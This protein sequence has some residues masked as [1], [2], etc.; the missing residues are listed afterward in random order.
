LIKASAL[1]DWCK[2]QIGCGYVYG[3]IDVICT[4]EYL[5]QKEKQY[6]P[7]MGNG[8]YQLNGDYT[9]GRCAKW[10][11]KRVYDCSGLIKSGRK[12]L[13]GPYLDVSAQ[14]CYDQCTKRGKVTDMPLT[15]GCTVYMWSDKKGRMGHVGLYI[16]NGK[17]IEARGADYGVVTTKLNER[18]WTHWGMLDW[19]EYDL[20]IESGKVV[21][22]IQADSGDATTPKPN[23]LLTLAEA[24]KFIDSKIDISE[25]LWAGTDTAAKAKYVD[26]LLQKIATKWR[27][28]KVNYNGKSEVCSRQNQ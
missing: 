5:K 15:P 12:H 13:G 28:E 2:K 22:G 26:L 9:K 27:K 4:V 14:G 20:K 21:V 24:V 6:G 17:V 7:L 11:D 23:D 10:L 25:D 18:Q 16:G 19:L 3:L 8:Y 1:I